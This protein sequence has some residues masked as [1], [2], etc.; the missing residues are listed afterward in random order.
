[1]PIS[2]IYCSCHLLLFF[3]IFVKA[4]PKCEITNQQTE[5]HVTCTPTDNSDYN[6]QRGLVSDNNDTIKLT[7]RACRISQ[8]ELEAFENLFALEYLDISQNKISELKLGVLDGMLQVNHLNLSHNLLTE[9]S[10]FDQK[11]N[12]NTLDLSGNKIENLELAI[13]DPLVKLKWLDLSDNALKGKDINPYIFDQSTKINYISFAR[14]NMNQSPENLL[15]ALE[16]LRTLNLDRCLLTEIP[17]F[18]TGRNLRTLRELIISTNQITKLDDATTFI[19]LENLNTLNLAYNVIKSIDFNTFK[20]LKKLRV[21]VLR[22]NKL[23]NIPDTLFKDMKSVGNIDLSHN[24]ITSI[25][26]NAFRG[27]SLKNLNLAS[28]RITY[29]TD[30]F[31]LELRNSGAIL[32]KFYFNQNPWQCACLRNILEEVKKYKIS[33][34]GVM[35]DGKHPICVTTSENSCKRHDTFNS[36]Y[37]ELYDRLVLGLQIDT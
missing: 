6:L 30:N 32:T 28:N 21:I 17:A 25:S 27:T 11:P 29:L 9:F 12:L 23:T 14:N 26:V 24:E 35:Y 1:M 8:V 16:D 33:Y 10:L 15:S 18:A 34:N 19:N 13:F 4:T 3:L 31:C 2:K 36:V 5:H 7:L 22:G 37:T 20:S